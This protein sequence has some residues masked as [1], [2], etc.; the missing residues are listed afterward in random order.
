MAAGAGGNCVRARARASRE[1]SR[2]VTEALGHSS[3]RVQAMQPLPVHKSRIF[4]EQ[5]G[6]TLSPH[7]RTFPKP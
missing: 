4:G 7:T 3:A 1:M 2:A 5:P 6:I